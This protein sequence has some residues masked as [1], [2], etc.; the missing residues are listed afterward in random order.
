M[1][2]YYFDIRDGN[3]LFPDDQGSE[4]DGLNAARIEAFAAL[5][6]YVKEI[7]PT[8]NRRRVA[9]EVR[10]EDSKPLL[11]AVVIFEVEVLGDS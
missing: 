7:A 5:A 6:D 4:M 11:K 3:R 10:D 1:A 2:L 9:I 8:E